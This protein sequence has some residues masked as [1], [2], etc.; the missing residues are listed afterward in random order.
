M[1]G[2]I[3]EQIPKIMADVPAIAKD[4]FN[5]GQKY[6]FRGI[7]DIYNALQSV[8]A[9]HGVFCVPRVIWERTEERITKSGTALIYRILKIKYRF[10]ADDGSF[11]DAIVV[12]EGM[13]SGDKAGNKAMSAAQKYAFLQVF[14]IPTEE[15]KDSENESHQ[16][17]P[18]ESPAREAAPKAEAAYQPTPAPIVEPVAYNSTLTPDRAWLH[19]QLLERNTPREIWSAVSMSMNNLPPNELER[20]IAGAWGNKHA[21]D[22]AASDAA[23]ERQRQGR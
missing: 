23:F 10:Y 5:A 17:K 1:A 16:L 8:L 15:Q 13:D 18:K 11:F 20:V 2:K 12:G 6:K 3:Y 14:S 7:D 4:N 22:A 21:L 19:Q 9:R